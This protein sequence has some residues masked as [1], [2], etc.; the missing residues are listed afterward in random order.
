MAEHPACSRWMNALRSA[1]RPAEQLPH[2]SASSRAGI[3]ATL[4]EENFHRM[5]AE[6][7]DR[8]QAA[9]EYAEE[10]ARVLHPA[11]G[12]LPRLDLVFLG[13]G[14]DGHTASLFPGSRGAGRTCTAWV[15]AQFRPTKL[16]SPIRLTLS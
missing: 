6:R 4:P 12:E 16:N 13:M 8:E 1:R 2:D 5:A 9:R 3:G 7:P 14:P 11:P 15:A 10:L